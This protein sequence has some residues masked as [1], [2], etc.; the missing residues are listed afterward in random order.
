MN[1]ASE[2]R[3]DKFALDR[4]GRRLLIEGQPAKVGARAFDVLVA[5][6]ERRPS[7]V[8]KSD[9]MDIVWPGL[10]VEEGNLQVQVFA[11]RKILGPGAITTIP[12]RGYQFSV[13]I[14]RQE[15]LVPPSR[16]ELKS[17]PPDTVPTKDHLLSAPILYG[18][19]VET[20]SLRALIAKHRL[21]SLIGPGGMGKTSLA[22]VVAREWRN[23]DQT[24]AAIVNLSSTEKPE[25]VA[26][27]ILRALG[28]TGGRGGQEV[29]FLVDARTG[30][31]IEF[32][33]ARARPER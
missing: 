10:A 11:L 9:L 29:A 3:F 30:R 4:A 7:V 13:A 5:L 8:A 6:V 12:G 17:G 23:L 16:P 1:R 27:T 2:I 32:R 22:R 15:P 24:R 25:L 33:M 31:R 18:R 26:S 14:E 28:V 19:D 21:V 20:A